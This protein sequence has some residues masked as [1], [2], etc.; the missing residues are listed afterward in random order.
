MFVYFL[1]SL[2]A[3]YRGHQQA[4]GIF[5]LNLITAPTVVGWLGSFY[6]AL[7][8]VGNLR[9]NI[10]FSPVH[11]D[12][13]NSSVPVTPSKPLIRSNIGEN[14]N[15]RDTLT[16]AGINPERQVSRQSNFTDI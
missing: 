8:N 3:T 12:L 6:W 4:F 1:P 7:S 9:R 5:V 2:I 13:G 15:T 16:T 10:A 14:L 11:T